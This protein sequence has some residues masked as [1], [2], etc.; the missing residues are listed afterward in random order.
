MTFFLSKNARR[1]NVGSLLIVLTGCFPPGSADS[2]PESFSTVIPDPYSI[3]ITG[4]NKSWSARYPDVSG[5][6]GAGIKVSA[7]EDIHVPLGAKIILILK[8]TDYLYTFSIPETGLKEIAVP[9]L[10]F[11]IEFQP[12]EA[13]QLDLVG[14]QL[15]GDPHSQVAGRL[16]IEPQDRFLEWCRGHC[17]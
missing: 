1:L 17:E 7:G 4:S 10:E 12:T 6:L 13:T 5:H 9:T 3:E 15:C 2:R 16:V 8:S 14:E 11:R